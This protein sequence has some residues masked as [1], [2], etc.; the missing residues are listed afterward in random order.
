MQ[1]SRT[2]G[3]AASV[4]R[5]RRPIRPRYTPVLTQQDFLDGGVMYWRVAVIDPDG[6]VGA[7]SKAKKF[8]LLARMQVQFTGQQA[9]GARQSSSSACSTPRASRVKGAAVK[10]TR[11]RRQDRHQEDEREGHRHLLGQGHARRQPHGHRDE[12]ALQGRRPESRRSRRTP[13]GVPGDDARHPCEARTATMAAVSVPETAETKNETR[14]D[15][16]RTADL[17]ATALTRYA[18]AFATFGLMALSRP[19]SPRSSWS[20]CA[21]RMPARRRS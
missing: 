7:F 1:V 14:G 2:P 4:P 21:A 18:Q 9:H 6:N 8:T 16:I 12:E 15:E 19:P 11:R 20:L 5:R 10:L 3:F 17:V 13:R